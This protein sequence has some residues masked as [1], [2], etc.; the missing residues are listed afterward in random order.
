MEGIGGCYV[1]GRFDGIDG[2]SGMGD[3][4]VGIDLRGVGGV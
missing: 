3:G 2:A 4:G 1:I